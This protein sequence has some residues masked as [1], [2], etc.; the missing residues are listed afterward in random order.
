[1]KKTNRIFTILIICA[2]LVGLTACGSSK[3][4]DLQSFY[5]GLSLDGM[6][7]LSG[8]KIEKFY[9]I[10]QDDCSQ[11]IVACGEDGLSVDEIWLF[12]AKDAGKASAIAGAAESHISQLEAETANYLPE[13]NAVIR[14][15]VCK[16]YGNYVLMIIHP[17]ADSIQS[18]FEDALK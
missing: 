10:S 16:T 1:M 12:E 9:G 15:A 17:S 4:V 6:Y 11:M 5:D 13:Q 7:C 18:R 14:N 3:S 8:D 2:L